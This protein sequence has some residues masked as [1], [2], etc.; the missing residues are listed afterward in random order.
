M[1]R[2]RYIGEH[3]GSVLGL[4]FGEG[5][6]QNRQRVIGSDSNARD[7]AIGEDEN[8]SDGV[9]MLLNLSRNALLMEFILLSTASVGQPR[10]V[11]DTNLGSGYA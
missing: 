1:K 3:E 6:G 11:E 8:G 5:G 4:D 7:S 9:G 10:C 2:A